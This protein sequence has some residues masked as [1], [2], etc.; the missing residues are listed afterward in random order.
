MVAIET[1]KKLL[2]DHFEALTDEAMN[3]IIDYIHTFSDE[4]KAGKLNNEGLVIIID[5]LSTIHSVC[6]Y[7]DDENYEKYNKFY[8]KVTFELIKGL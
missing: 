1:V 8:D 2:Y 4:V 6:D 3:T 5:L 7:L